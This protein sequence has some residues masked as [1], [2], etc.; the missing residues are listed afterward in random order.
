M[1]LADGRLIPGPLRG[2]QHR[3]QQQNPHQHQRQGGH[4]WLGRHHAGRRGSL[5]TPD[6]P[7]RNPLTQARTGTGGTGGPAG[8]AL[9]CPGG[10]EGAGGEA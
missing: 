5:Q 10:G 3:Q 8:G 9:R 2:H 7:P 4:R 1:A 6:E